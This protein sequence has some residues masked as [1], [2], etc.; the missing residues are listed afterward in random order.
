MKRLLLMATCLIGWLTMSA[1]APQILSDRHAMLRINAQSRYLLLPIQEREEIANI[2]IIVNPESMYAS[3]ADIQSE[4]I[5]LSECKIIW[6]HYHKDGGVDG[7]D[8]FAANAVEALAAKNQLRTFY[9]NGGAM[10]LTRYATNLPSFIGVTG[11]DEW[12]TPNNSM[13][14]NIRRY[15]LYG[16]ERCFLPTMQQS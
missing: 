8:A 14:C 16:L 6:W 2:S 7:H 15:A 1:Q 12:T 10:L 11:D 13:L 4:Q 9:E 3:F 5:D